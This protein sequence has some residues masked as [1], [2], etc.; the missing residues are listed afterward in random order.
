MIPQLRQVFADTAYWIALLNPRDQLHHS[1][2]VASQSLGR[3]HLITSDVVLTEFLN[4]FAGWGPYWR[5]MAARLVDQL[6]QNTQTVIEPQT[7]DLFT[8]AFR[9]YK[10]REDKGYGLTDCTSM[11]IMER[12][13]IH[14]V[15]SSD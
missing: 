10:D 4:S 13:S 11:V 8:A 5:R 12:R 7:R 1:A 14:E 3:T 6:Y 2:V 15:L 9:R